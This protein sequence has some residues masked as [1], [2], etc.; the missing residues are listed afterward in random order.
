[1]I[2]ADPYLRLRDLPTPP[3]EICSCAD[4]PPLLLYSNASQNPL[5]CFACNLSVPPEKILLPVALVDELADWR[6]FRAAFETL[7]LDSGEFEDWARELLLDP[8]SPPN[9]RGLAVAAKLNG[10]RASYMHWFED[11]GADEPV[12]LTSCPRC[13]GPLEPMGRGQAC[14]VCLIGVLSRPEAV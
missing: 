5:H 2:S 12:A 13:T 3:E 10:H 9:T 1:M 4:S 6:S 11:A 8:A 14:K 7:W